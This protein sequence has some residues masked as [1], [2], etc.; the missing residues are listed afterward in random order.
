MVQ[1]SGSITNMPKNIEELRDDSTFKNIIV[2][3]QTWFLVR[4]KWQHEARVTLEQ[5]ILD[6]QKEIDRLS[7]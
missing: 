6:V 2:R 3:L 1:F 4:L 7:Q 5:L